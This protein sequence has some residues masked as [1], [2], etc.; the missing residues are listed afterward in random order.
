VSV[1]DHLNVQ[2]GEY[3]AG[4]GTYVPHYEEM[5]DRLAG[6]LRTLDA[7]RP[8]I[9]DLGIGTGALSARCLEALGAARVVGVDADPEMLEVAA[10]RLEGHE[11]A[12]LI[13]GD[14][15]EVPLPDCDAV[16]ACISL[17]H[18]ATPEGKRTLYR[19]CAEALR[20]GGLLLSGDRFLATDP[21]LRE[22]EREAWLAHLGRTYTPE[23]SEA[24]LAAW[25]E[26]DFYFPLADELAWIEEAGLSPDVLWRADGFAVVAGRRV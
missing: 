26:E 19:R 1:A 14:F 21:A 20:P 2:A 6:A 23:E 17:H 12:E 10:A 18:V 5:I 9:V 25:A 13:P 15:L 7:E 16:V 22:T 24:H 11:E 4:I 8:T 3:D